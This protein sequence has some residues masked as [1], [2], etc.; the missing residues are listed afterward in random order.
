MRA[1][2]EGIHFYKTRKNETMKIIAKYM[3]T[4]DMEAGN[5]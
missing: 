5:L 2:V 4:D 1:F 3:R